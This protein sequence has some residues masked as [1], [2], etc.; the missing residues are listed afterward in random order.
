MQYYKDDTANLAIKQVQEV[1]TDCFAFEHGECSALRFLVCKNDAFKFY[2][3][4][5]D[6]INQI[7]EMYGISDI[8]YYFKIIL[9]EG[10]HKHERNVY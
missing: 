10:N 8:K 6:F 5:L 7:E 1:K 3:A 4:K 9:K 2:K